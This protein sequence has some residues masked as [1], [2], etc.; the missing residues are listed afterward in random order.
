MVGEVDRPQAGREGDSPK[1]RAIVMAMPHSNIDDRTR[2]TAKR[3]RRGQ[4]DTER[5][6]WRLLRP[7]RDDGISFRR[8]APVGVYIVDFVWLSGRLVIE[9]D[10]GQHNEATGLARDAARTQW[11]ES[12][13]FGGIALLEQRRVTQWRGMSGG[14]CAGN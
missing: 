7:F 10:G 6:M 13:R 14:H 9:V 11:L 3:L 4:T 2:T 5:K 8:Q 12:Q 1:A